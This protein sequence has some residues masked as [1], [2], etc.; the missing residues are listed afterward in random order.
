MTFKSKHIF[1]LTIIVFIFANNE[2][3]HYCCCLIFN[4]YILPIGC[5]S[6]PKT[7]HSSH[8][9]N[10]YNVVN[11]NKNRHDAIK[12]KSF[13]N[14]SSI[15]SLASF[16]YSYVPFSKEEKEVNDKLK[17]SAFEWI[18]KYAKIRRYRSS[19][20]SSS[21]SD[22]NSNIKLKR[23]NRIPQGQKATFYKDITSKDEE[24]ALDVP[25]LN[26]NLTAN[27]YM[28]EFVQNNILNKSINTHLRNKKSHQKRSTNY[29]RWERYKDN[30][31][32]YKTIIRNKRELDHLRNN[33]TTNNKTKEETEKP[34]V[35]NDKKKTSKK[36]KHRRRIY[37][38]E[39]ESST[40][41][42]ILNGQ[43]ALLTCTVRNV[44]NKSVSYNFHM[45]CKLFVVRY[46]TLKNI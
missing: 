9:G 40:N 24:L 20:C 44:G 34:I 26:T 37:F 33:E 39:K 45:S 22:D 38:D 32:F 4:S 41:V 21:A 6:N 10:Q 16:N 3:F 17:R 29:Y 15:P 7:G 8:N 23:N 12:P 28:S 35:L 25:R 46:C 2:E 1:T 31:D 19:S 27:A 36:R 14:I 18:Q 42:T 43:T 30:S 5:G 13:I 11:I